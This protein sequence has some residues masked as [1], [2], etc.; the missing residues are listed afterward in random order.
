MKPKKK[1]RG[2]Q[3]KNAATAPAPPPVQAPVQPSKERTNV[4][5]PVAP[6]EGQSFFSLGADDSDSDDDVDQSNPATA[7]NA[8]ATL[9]D[10]DEEMNDA[11]A[12]GADWGANLS[13]DAANDD[14]EEDKDDDGLWGEARKQAE[15]S[16]AREID[17]AKREEKIRA[18]AEMASKKRMEEAAALGEQARAKREE[19]EAE[20]ARLL[21]EKEREAEEA[22]IAAR[23]KALQEVNDVQNTVD[24]DA[25]RELMKQYEQE[26]D[27]YSGGASPASDFGF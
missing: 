16:K 13:Q 24:L 26:Y 12:F 4:P 11:D 20:A 6:S 21:E 23:E 27:N 3:P 15:V 10:N 19:E 1:R 18:D 9:E 22:K 7:T 14:A 5:K 25:Q 2:R 8:F 17:R